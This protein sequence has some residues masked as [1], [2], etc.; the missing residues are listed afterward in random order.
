MNARRVEGG[1]RTREPSDIRTPSPYSSAVRARSSINAPAVPTLYGNAGSKHRD[2]PN[3]VL[4]RTA[5]VALWRPH[6]FLVAAFLL[7]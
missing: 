3:R 1:V 2:Q 4:H 7:G 5:D 6:G